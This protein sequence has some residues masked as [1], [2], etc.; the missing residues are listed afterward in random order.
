MRM[1]ERKK[2]TGMRMKVTRSPIRGP[3]GVLEITIP[4]F[5]P[6]IGPSI[7]FFPK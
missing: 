4:S 1:K 2:V 3:Q 6:R 5:F 7:N